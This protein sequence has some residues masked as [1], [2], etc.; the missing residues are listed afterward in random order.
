M[1]KYVKIIIIS[2]LLSCVC[3]F[4]LTKFPFRGREPLSPEE[5]PSYF[6]LQLAG[7]IIAFTIKKWIDQ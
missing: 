2:I 5:V 7:F 1:K 3:T 4:I 6:F